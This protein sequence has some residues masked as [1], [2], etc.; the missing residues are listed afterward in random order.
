MV[1]TCTHNLCFEQKIEKYQIFSAEKFQFLKLKNICVLHAQDFV[2]ES[3]FVSKCV[4]TGG[5]D[6]S[7]K[8][9]VHSLYLRGMIQNNVDF[10]RSFYTYKSFFFL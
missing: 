1:L 8:F 7:A 10:C 9:I 6:E 4:E 5:C 2:M 3:K